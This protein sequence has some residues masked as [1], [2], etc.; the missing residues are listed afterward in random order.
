MPEFE[1]FGFKS[2]ED[3]I[4]YIKQRSDDI[5]EVTLSVAN[6]LLMIGPQGDQ[7]YFR[8]AVGNVMHIGGDSFVISTED[9][10]ALINDGILSRL[11]VPI[12]LLALHSTGPS[13]NQ[14][15]GE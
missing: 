13:S 10:E 15:E 1:N 7:K 6:G 11:R 3:L 4:A 12:R 2:T 9:A 14:V 8:G 5:K